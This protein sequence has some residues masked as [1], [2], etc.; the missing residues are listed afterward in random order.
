MFETLDLLFLIVSVL[1]TAQAIFLIVL[2]M[3][4][5]KRAF[6]A[7]RWLMVFGFSVGMSFIDDT[8]DPMISPLTNLYLVPVFAPFF[9]ALIPS[10]YLYFR[11]I[12]G[13][14]APRPYRHFLVLLPVTAA[15]GLMV[16][17]K[18]ARMIANNGHI[19]D[20]G[21]QIEFSA[22]GLADMVLLAI[23]ILFCVLF[24]VYMTGI[25]RCARRYLQQADWQLQADSERLRRWVTELLVGMTVLFTV[26]TLTNLFDL[27]VS[28][29][30]WLSLGVKVGFVLVF[31]RMC[32]VIAQNPALFVQPETEGGVFDDLSVPHGPAQEPDDQDA[33]MS[34]AI[35]DVSNIE[36][37]RTRLERIVTDRNVML[38]PLLTM[39]KLA[40]AV[41]VTPNQ[42]SYVLN[43]HLG[44]SF[45]DFVNEVRTN[46]A[47]RLLIEEPDR[48][49]LDIAIS[50]G[51]NSKSTF[52]LAFKKTTGKTPSVYRSET[53][54]QCSTGQ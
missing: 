24:A 36:R 22:T 52:N 18:R 5:G 51:F 11:E 1:G 53:L 2:L 16:Y 35:V 15:I 50:V 38:D 39:P 25:W 42:L 48:T 47:S 3:D 10:I 13:D 33:P 14:P 21:L 7:N 6:T 46:E 29:A 43:Q 37:I 23:V 31:F 49:I 54:S 20:A 34:R 44:K 17:L 28:R 27:F 8:F 19:R 26:F 41:G 4:E 9:F 30:E 40:N 12:S 45:F 32:Q